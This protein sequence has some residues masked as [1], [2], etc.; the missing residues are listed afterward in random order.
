MA[1]FF[2]GILLALLA[3]SVPSLGAAQDLS[4]LSATPVRVSEGESTVYGKYRSVRFLAEAISVPFTGVLFSV[5]TDAVSLAG[6]IRFESAT[7]WTDWLELYLLPRLNSTD[8]VASY[9]DGV[10]RTGRFEI[11]LQAVDASRVSVESAATF[12]SRL[13]AD[14]QQVEWSRVDVA[15]A[16]STGNVRA[17]YLI[18]R[19]EWGAESF[20]GEPIPLARP[21]YDRITFH[22]AACCGA[23]LYEEGIAQVRW[24]QQFHQDGRGWSDIGYHFVMDQSGRLYQGRPFL[25]TSVPL[26]DGPVLAQ[27]AH[28]GGYNRGNIGISVLGCYHPPEGPACMDVL[29]PAALDSLVNAIA[30]LSERYQV[31]G[32][33]IF[34][35]RDFSSTACPGDNNYRLLPDIR[36]RV[37]EIKR[38]GSLPVVSEYTLSEP[39]PNPAGGGVTLRY[40][41][42][43]EGIADL[44]IHDS[45]GRVIRVVDEGFREA[46]RWNTVAIDTSDLSPGVYFARLTVGG[47]SGTAFTASR[48][49]IV[50]R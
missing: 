47:F 23:Y 11:R 6:Q 49:L 1:N 24:I 43:A 48:P 33:E 19:E 20:R 26:A 34:G 8:V 30:F 31:P 16:L 44:R 15:R 37:E 9:R 38:F 45:L 14:A 5:G 2:R 46:D 3:A 32:T 10:A 21:S 42:D 28:V 4:D 40:F 35:H 39:F 36:T 12:D 7:G 50:V 22:H 17:P 13:N 18:K 41:M 27:G 25:N 29:S